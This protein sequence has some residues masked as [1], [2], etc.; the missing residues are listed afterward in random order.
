M[1]Q[2]TADV[3]IIG[4]GIT[5]TSAA[6]QLALRGQRVILLEKTAIAAGGTGRTGGILRQ[7]YS[8]TITARMAMLSLKVW[9]D[10]DNVVGGEVGFQRTGALF[11][12]DKR[13]EEGLKANI[14]LQ[15]GVGINTD[16]LD[17]D[18]LRELVPYL[19][20][21][22]LGGGA[23]EPDAGCADG[24]M[25]ANAFAKRAR[26]LGASVLQGVKVT[27]ILT[28]GSRVTG[29]ETD[30]GEFSAPVVINAAGPWGAV[31]A[32]TVGYDV[33]VEASRHQISVFRQPE[34]TLPKGHPMI[35]DFVQGFYMRPET[36]RISLAGSLE[37]T[38]AAHRVDPDNYVETV[39][40][41]FNADMAERTEHRMPLMGEASVGKGWAGLY[42]V[43]P[44]WSPVLGRMPGLDGFVC[45][46]GWSGS[47]FK[48]GPVVG[49]M[50]A[51]LA[52]G[53]Q[54]CPIDPHIFRFERF[55]EGDLVKGQYAYSIIG[56]R[57]GRR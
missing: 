20:V 26:D 1:A 10:F 45:A 34:G 2:Q 47:G 13:D 25:A 8:N 4:G 48:M 49:E 57:W 23:Y 41:D 11:I 30:Q 51:D 16:F 3:I 6:Y 37:A 33:P 46:F 15:K 28:Q 9:A 42:D 19:N 7:H 39:D 40:M 35:G 53:E 52:T 27:R 55:A 54:R 43:S 36:G 17:A 32:E 18:S 56:C 14:A 21:E 50:L 38:E 44:D 22:D 24:S 29:V 5:G 12:V 31:L